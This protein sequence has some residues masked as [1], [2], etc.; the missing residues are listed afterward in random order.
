MAIFE[1]LAAIDPETLLLAATLKRERR[2][3]KRKVRTIALRTRDRAGLLD[4][5]AGL[6]N[7][8]AGGGVLALMGGS[9][10]SIVST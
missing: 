8:R 9:D 6:L 2:G 3:M 1:R 5:R 10:F 7:D 4:D